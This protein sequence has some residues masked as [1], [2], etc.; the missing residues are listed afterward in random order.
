M[1]NEIVILARFEITINNNLNIYGR[2]RETYS[3]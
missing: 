3:D 2:R 1:T